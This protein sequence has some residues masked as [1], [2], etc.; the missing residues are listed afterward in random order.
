MRPAQALMAILLWLAAV[1]AATAQPVPPPPDIEAGAYILQ[2]HHS[3]R[4]LAAKNPDKRMEPASLTKMMTAYAV[5]KEIESGNLALDEEVWISERAWKM[6]G[7]RTFV[8]V[9]TKVDVETL[10]KGV[11]VQS[12]ND[13]SVALAERVA[14]TEEA[15][16]QLM[17]QYARELGMDNTHFTNSTGLPDPDLYTTARDMATMVRALVRD[18][19][20][21]YKWHAIRE[22]TYN[23]ITQHNRNRLLWRDESVDGVKTGYTES[24]GYCLAAS[25]EREGMRLISVVMGSESPEARTR[26]IQSLLTY[27]FRFYE[28][29]R[30]YAASEAL[31]E[32][33]VWKGSRDSLGVGL[34]EDLYVTVPAGEYDKLSASMDLEAAIMAPVEQGARQGTVT[35]TFGED[36]IAERPLVALQSVAEGGLWRRLTDHVRLMLQ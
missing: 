2:D 15:F 19:P 1:C 28:T 14:G 25:A 29:H 34:T 31:T 6:I 9:D 23:N 30:L 33:R 5:F 35:V 13:A 7:S 11:I 24:A 36:T 18:F 4:V 16:A 12:G 20:E 22:Y 17:N 27:G 32:V 10:L 3:G 8:E 26:Q 21:L